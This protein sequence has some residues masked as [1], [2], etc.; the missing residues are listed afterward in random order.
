MNYERWLELV[1][2]LNRIIDD[3]EAVGDWGVVI[4]ALRRLKEVLP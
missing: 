4:E 3:A 2:A 1:G